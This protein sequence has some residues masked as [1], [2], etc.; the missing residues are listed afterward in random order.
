MP[1]AGRPAARP[2]MLSS[3]GSG[4]G[5]PH[6]CLPACLVSYAAPPWPPCLAPLSSA[7]RPPARGS[8]GGQARRRRALWPDQLRAVHP[9]GAAVSGP[10]SR[11]PPLAAPACSRLSTLRLCLLAMLEPP[12]LSAPGLLMP[13]MSGA[14]TSRQLSTDPP[15]LAQSTA[16]HPSL[17][18][19]APA[20]APTPPTSAGMRRAR[21][22]A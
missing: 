18:P 21:C 10:H 16:P 14:G 15:K 11:H 17:P 7:G 3:A 1:A 5:A 4:P 20:A 22:G 19:G 12:I 8:S 9:A 2:C 13:C 6:A